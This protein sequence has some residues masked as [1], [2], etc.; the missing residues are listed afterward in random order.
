MADLL[1]HSPLPV[2]D[3][4]KDG[5]PFRWIVAVAPKVRAARQVATDEQALQRWRERNAA[6]LPI[7][8]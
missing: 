5:N 2:Y 7:S 3:A 4:T 8:Q 6:R 1:R